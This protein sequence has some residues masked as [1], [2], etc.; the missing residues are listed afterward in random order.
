M[1]R[2]REVQVLPMQLEVFEM[3]RTSPGFD[4]KGFCEEKAQALECN[5]KFRAKKMRARRKS[6]RTGMS[7]AQ[8]RTAAAQLTSVAT[9]Y[10]SNMFKAK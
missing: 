7:G 3:S 1:G 6:G 4:V 9:N 8:P 5:K 2:T 10:F